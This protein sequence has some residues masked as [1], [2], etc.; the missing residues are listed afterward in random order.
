MF[1]KTF[2][3][4]RDKA[5]SKMGP[6]FNY[7][8][9][10][11]QYFHPDDWAQMSPEL[12][13]AFAKRLFIF[14]VVDEI[15]DSNHLEKIPKFMVYGKYDP[16]FGRQ[17]SLVHP[18]DGYL[19]SMEELCEDLKSE[20]AE[21]KYDE[22]QLDENGFPV[23]LDLNDINPLLN[24]DPELF[25]SP[26]LPDI[27]LPE[28][29]SSYG[30]T[31]I[32]P[33]LLSSL[34]PEFDF[35]KADN[36]LQVEQKSTGNKNPCNTDL[37]NENAEP[38][39]SACLYD[40]SLFSD[41]IDA[42]LLSSLG[43]E[44][45]FTKADNS[46]QVEQKSTGN[47]NPCHTDLENENA[48]PNKSTRLYDPSLFSDEIDA[49]LL[50]SLGPE[51]DFTNTPSTAQST[52]QISDSNMNSAPQA[53]VTN[54]KVVNQKLL[55]QKTLN[56]Q[57]NSTGSVKSTQENQRNLPQSQA[58]SSAKTNSKST[59]RNKRRREPEP[60]QKPSSLDQSSIEKE[61][62]NHPD[63][64]DEEIQRQSREE[65]KRLGF[66][67]HTAKLRNY[68]AHLGAAERGMDSEMRRRGLY[69]FHT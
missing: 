57:K 49:E 68:E 14:Y 55:P 15:P 47:K 52:K 32:D 43:P 13:Q 9:E 2:L 64:Y 34:G 54:A 38:N 22:F 12:K 36:S 40:P 53:S 62:E 3:E 21:S 19:F 39:K 42:E 11:S 50:S 41:E 29:L 35:T 69:A 66:G 59:K 27:E 58:Q 8:L 28:L 67:K 4:M 44:F 24:I 23:V 46:L 51:F 60:Q 31:D 5:K 33:E 6:D 61:L 65:R 25:S 10:A 1:K 18:S 16:S 45:D 30:L 26:G 37:E 56:S 63:F 7:R 17:Y 20:Y 48:E